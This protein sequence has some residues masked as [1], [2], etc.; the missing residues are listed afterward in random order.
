[1]ACLVVGI[2][3][4]V[5]QQWL[6]VITILAGASGGIGLSLKCAPRSRSA[7]LLA[8]RERTAPGG[9]FSCRAVASTL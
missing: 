8:L 5:L 2:I 4:C 6:G 3:S 9:R 1:M 7:R